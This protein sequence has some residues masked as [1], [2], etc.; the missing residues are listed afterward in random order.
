LS[1]KQLHVP[2]KEVPVYENLKA[3][4]RD[5]VRLIDHYIL[6]LPMW[7]YENNVFDCRPLAKVPIDPAMHHSHVRKISWE[8][9]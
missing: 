1:L 9:W 8:L 5:V 2:N 7:T 3:G 6:K 4:E